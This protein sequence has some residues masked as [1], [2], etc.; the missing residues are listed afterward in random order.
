MQHLWRKSGWNLWHVLGALGMAIAAS[1]V[2]RQS[3]A[4]ILQIA[5]IDEEASHV[6]LV[7][8]LF[9]WL[10]WIRLPRLRRLRASGQWV[11][12]VITALGA[13]VL[14]IGY[15]N[16]IESFWHAGAILVV[17]GAVLSVL[18][19]EVLIAFLPAFC[20][21]A[22]AVPVP[23]L[24]RQAVA[25]RM[26]WATAAVTQQIF[27][28]LGMDID[29]SANMLS[30]RGVPV[31]VAEACNGM[32]M[33]FTLVLVSY[34]FAF[35]TPLKGYIRLLILAMCPAVAIACN[36]IRLI[37]TIYMFGVMPLAWAEAF[38]TVSGWMMLPIAFMLLY[39]FIGL[40]RWTL[41][42]IRT[43][44]LAYD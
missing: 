6:W 42:P 18:G 4:D 30:I 31:L 20:V 3:L 17:V 15:Q 38:H 19:L 8:L 7:P 32:R 5:S 33:V 26:Q 10:V 21:L 1:W 37:P 35:G 11:G 25:V 44:T 13:A 23:G 39:G 28:V 16:G 34:A 2:C 43:F 36:V 9:A 27:D 24:L 12:A 22:F 41:L 14:M 40:L 29:R